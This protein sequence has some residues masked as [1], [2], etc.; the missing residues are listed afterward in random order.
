MPKFK[1]LICT[2]E[3]AEAKMNKW[4]DVEFNAVDIVILPPDNVDLLTDDEE[5]QD[6]HVK[7]QLLEPIIEELISIKHVKN[8]IVELKLRFFWRNKQIRWP[9]KYYN[10]L[11]CWRFRNIQFTTAS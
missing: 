1:R 6:D 5:A 3:A 8:D 11:Q 2:A 9:K 10:I 4:S 7:L